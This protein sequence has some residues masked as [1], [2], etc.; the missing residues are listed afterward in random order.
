MPVLQVCEAAI[1]LWLVSLDRPTHGDRGVVFPRGEALSSHDS[2]R[3][4]RVELLAQLRGRLS[5]RDAVGADWLSLDSQALVV[6][7]HLALPVKVLLYNRAP[8][9]M[10][11]DGLRM[12]GQHYY[13]RFVTVQG[14]FAARWS[15]VA[16]VRVQRRLRGV[17]QVHR[18]VASMR[19]GSALLLAC[20]LPCGL[21][22]D[23]E[24]L[25]VLMHR[26]QHV[27]V[28]ER[29][30]ASRHDHCGVLVLTARSFVHFG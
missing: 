30:C 2:A 24:V 19:R 13:R 6:A 27:L 25:G 26:L 23:I 12:L 16:H 29:L 8:L 22:T 20:L 1:G 28:L 4:V 21:R 18:E 14:L 9:S 17:G 5:S 15:H 11:L 10:I 3:L 7:H